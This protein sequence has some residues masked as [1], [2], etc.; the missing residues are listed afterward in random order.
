MSSSRII[1]GNEYHCDKWRFRTHKY[2][3]STV[4]ISGFSSKSDDFIRNPKKDEAPFLA[5]P[6]IYPD[7]IEIPSTISGKK[8]VGIRDAAFQ[9]KG[10]KGII[11]PD[12]VDSIGQRCFNG[13]K[14][15]EVVILPEKAHHVYD[16]AFHNCKKLHTIKNLSASQYVV[17]AFTGCYELDDQYV[18][19]LASRRDSQMTSNGI[20]YYVRDAGTTSTGGQVSVQNAQI[21][22]ITGLMGKIGKAK[23]I[24]IPTYIKG[25]RV[26]DIWANA[27]NNCPNLRDIVFPP[28]MYDVSD[29]LASGCPALSFETQE[30]IYK[31][32]Q[33]AHYYG[34]PHPKYPEYPSPSNSVMNMRIAL[35]Q[36][37][38]K[39][40]KIGI[41]YLK[42]VLK[43]YENNVFQV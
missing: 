8:V 38:I 10:F 14:N 35:Y 32:Y 22:V 21:V 7:Y 19:M 15:L 30:E 25:L 16:A 42:I 4:Q 27:F 34:K 31:L 29:K 18:T 2:G 9:N 6:N 3:Y 28:N 40:I 26:R 33:I 43:N 5:N 39:D 1:D 12:T 17:Q 13:C 11:I 37:N 36:N 23:K 20:C 41:E 24:V